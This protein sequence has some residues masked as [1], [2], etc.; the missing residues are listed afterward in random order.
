M[1]VDQLIAFYGAKNKSDLA[2]K[3]NVCRS[4]ITGW[5]QSG[6]PFRAQTTFEVLTKGKL[7]ADLRALTA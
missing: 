6:I 7:K 4:T 1:T 2:R 5:A 3:I